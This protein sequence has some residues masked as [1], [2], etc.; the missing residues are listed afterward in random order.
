MHC[1]KNPH[2]C[3]DDEDQED[4]DHNVVDDDDD[5][6]NDDD[7]DMIIMYSTLYIRKLTYSNCHAV[8]LR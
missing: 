1:S 4:E 3:S 6:S 5:D 8:T 7:Y 2:D